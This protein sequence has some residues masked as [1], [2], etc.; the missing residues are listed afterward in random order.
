M[1]LRLRLPSTPE[2]AKHPAHHAA[3]TA[4]RK[5]RVIYDIIHCDGEQI[6]S[7]LNLV[8]NLRLKRKKSAFVLTDQLPVQI[9]FCVMRYR[10]TAKQKPLA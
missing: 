6:L 1:I 9:N 10:V 8:C 2:T 3:L 7:R 4:N 5:R